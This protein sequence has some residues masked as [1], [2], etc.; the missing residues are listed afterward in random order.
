MSRAQGWTP[1]GAA[2]AVWLGSIAASGAPTAIGTLVS[3]QVS[4]ASYQDYLDNYLYTH[5]GDNRAGGQ[6]DNI[7]ARGN[8]AA[9]FQSFGLNVQLFPFPYNGQTYYNVVATQIG[10][11]LPNEVYIVGAHFDSVGNPGADDDA[12]GVAAVLEAARVV[13][14]Y[15]TDRTIRYIAFDQE[16]NG[17]VGSRAYANSLAGQT[18]RGMVQLDMITHNSGTYTTDIFGRTASNPLKSQ[19]ST[20]LLDYGN[21]LGT[22]VNGALNASDHAP[23]EDVG[24][25]ACALIE[26]NYP[27]NACYHRL[28]DAVETANHIHYAMGTDVTRGVAGFLADHAVVRLRG[29]VN[30]DGAVNNFDIDPFVLALTDASAYTAAFPACAVVL[31][32]VNHDGL[33]NNFDIDAFVTLLTP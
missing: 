32:D 26:D 12:S 18:I 8:I 25:Q 33:V 17:L 10:I 22:Q 6:P 24:I 28:C 7:A 27:A 9:L 1:I 2:L 3:T 5:T 14:Q 23:F 29:D 21:N 4:Q 16:E 20:A 31:A 13:S 15:D 30:C 11:R 19:V